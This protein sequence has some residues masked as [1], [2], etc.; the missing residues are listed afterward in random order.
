MLFRSVAL[1]RVALSQAEIQTVMS[2]GV[3]RFIQENRPFQLTDIPFSDG[4][5]AIIIRW[6]S[7]I[8]ANYA[9]DRSTDLNTAWD[10]I[11]ISQPS[12]GTVTAYTDNDVPS[13]EGRVFYRVRLIAQ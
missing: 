6:N 10:E 3:R 12:T 2:G 13:N 8:D 4:D 1:F 9:V 11:Q 7:E 5:E